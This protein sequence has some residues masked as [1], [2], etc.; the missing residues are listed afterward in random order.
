MKII[1]IIEDPQRFMVAIYITGYPIVKF[2]IDFIL[3]YTQLFFKNLRIIMFTANPL[4][5]SRTRKR[6]LKKAYQYKTI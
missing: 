2:F 5:A 3:N 1:I 6:E 4:D